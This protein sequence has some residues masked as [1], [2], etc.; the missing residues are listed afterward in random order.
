[1]SNMPL[2]E[3]RE[4]IAKDDGDPEET[5]VHTVGSAGNVKYHDPS[6]ECENWPDGPLVELTR[7]EAQTQD[8]A[9]CKI[10]IL[11]DI[12]RYNG[13]PSDLLQTMERDDVT[14]LDDLQE[15]MD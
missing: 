9:P 12:C 6:G 14:S 1:M 8:I 3:R 7:R 11:D 5:V 13:G 2:S 4:R 15:A 10:C